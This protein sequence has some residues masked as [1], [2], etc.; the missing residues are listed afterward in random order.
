MSNLSRS[1]PIQNLQNPVLNDGGGPNLSTAA[2]VLQKYRELE[3]EMPIPAR[4]DQPQ[5]YQPPPP[6]RVPDMQDADA[7]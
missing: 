2:G 4:G 3:H 1:T 7:A 6:G 5:N